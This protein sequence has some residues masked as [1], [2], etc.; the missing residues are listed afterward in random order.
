M[1]EGAVDAGL[2]V[3]IAPEP[4]IGA[5]EAHDRLW[6]EAPQ[7]L[8]VLLDDADDLA[9]G[10]H[11]RGQIAVGLLHRRVRKRL[12]DLADGSHHLFF[13]DAKRQPDVHLKR[14][15]R[16]HHV[17]L[18]ATLDG[19]DVERDLV[20]D[21]AGSPP[22]GAIHGGAPGVDGTADV[23][24]DLRLD[25][26]QLL[27]LGGDGH[28][29]LGGALAGMGVGAVRTRS[30]HGDLEPEWPLLAEAHTKGARGLA[31][32]ERMPMHFWMVLHEVA[33]TVGPEG[34]LIRYGGQRELALELILETIEVGVREDRRRRAGLHVGD[35]TAVDLAVD[36][37]P[38]PGIL[39]PT[40]TV[41]GHREYVDVAIEDEMAAGAPA[42]EAADDVGH[43]GVRRDDAVGQSAQIEEPLHEIGDLAGI[44]G[45]IGALVLHERLQEAHEVLA[46]A[47]DP[48]QNLLTC[49]AH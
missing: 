15:A 20:D 42:I 6:P 29:R 38:T 47:I 21:R 36:N 40:R 13:A 30:A 31:V 41:V 26:S 35:A 1:W 39:R 37:L 3:A 11:P 32:E 8:D 2:N 45:G 43:F 27:Q 46:V 22:H 34:F 10:I 9:V 18:D 23:V 33:R 17:D 25:G 24:R 44:P 19:T 12:K 48:V 28:G 49:R 4:R 7:L 16:G 5:A 14:G